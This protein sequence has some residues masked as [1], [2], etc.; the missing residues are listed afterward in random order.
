[1]QFAL[2]SSALRTNT[3]SI[4]FHRRA[5]AR[6][7]FIA[8]YMSHC[9]VFV[10]LNKACSMSVNTKTVTFPCPLSVGCDS[11]LQTTRFFEVRYSIAPNS[12][13]MPQDAMEDF[14]YVHTDYR[15]RTHK[16][17][18]INGAHRLDIFLHKIESNIR[19]SYVSSKSRSFHCIRRA[20]PYPC[21][22]PGVRR[23]VNA[24]LS[25]EV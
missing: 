24:P 17:D 25:S 15:Q 20:S 21:F 6:R 8:N 19:C 18:G 1:M 14:A 9:A 4:F 12:S 11:N 22:P 16:R 3:T 13:F 2:A 23:V 7:N 10:D 5:L